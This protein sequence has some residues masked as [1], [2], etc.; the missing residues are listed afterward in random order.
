MLG[1]GGFPGSAWE[2]GLIAGLFEAGIDLTTADLVVG[3]SAGSVVGAQLTSGASVPEVYAAQLTT[4]SSATPRRFGAREALHFTVALV[5][6]RGD[7]EAL[8]RRLGAWSAR[9]EQRG[10]TLSP[11]ER[12]ATTDWRLRG[13]DWP[14][15]PRLLVTAVDQVTG[16]LRVFDG[17]DGVP[18]RDAVTAS[19]AVP[20]V[21]PP[22]PIAGRRYIDGGARSGGNA[23]LARG[24]DLVLALMPRDRS[25][26][27]MR[28]VAQQL[29][30]VP[31]LVIGP[32]EKGAAAVGANLLDPASQVA[33]ARAG[34]AQAAAVADAVREHWSGG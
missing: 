34:H 20:G 29:E 32:D 14:D 16:R 11:E 25:V 1:G 9:E 2:T 19:T 23:D 17:T 15:P 33:S 26:G 24:C 22:V 13:A 27:P 3:T 21:Y 12:Y 6:A 8:G 5:R 10:R 31:T 18:L 28:S 4:P 30:G 7:V